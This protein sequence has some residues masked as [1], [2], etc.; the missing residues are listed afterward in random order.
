MDTEVGGKMFQET[1]SANLDLFS[2]SVPQGKPQET[3]SLLGSVLLLRIHAG[4]TEP[5]TLTVHSNI[6]K[7]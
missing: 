1:G 5:Q 2:Q 3:G 4:A 6:L 7:P